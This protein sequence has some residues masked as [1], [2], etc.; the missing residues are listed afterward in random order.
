MKRCNCWV[1][2]TKNK[3]CD[4]SRTPISAPT[5]IVP[6]VLGANTLSR[7]L[8]PDSKH[9][10]T[11]AYST[12][13]HT[14]LC[15]SPWAASACTEYASLKP[16]HSEANDGTNTDLTPMSIAHPWST[17]TSSIP[18]ISIPWWMMSTSLKTKMKPVTCSEMVKWSTTWVFEQSAAKKRW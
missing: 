17:C 5:S 10:C 3:V 4:A 9:T 14:L 11:T 18:L 2:T 6:A 12:I 7:T 1:P 16:T 13:S 15:H 8:S